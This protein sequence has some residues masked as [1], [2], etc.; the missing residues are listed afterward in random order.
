MGKIFDKGLSEDDQKEGLFKRLESIE[1]KNE[2]Q[3]QGIKDREEKKLREIKNINK[4]NTLKVIDEIRKKMMKQIRYYLKLRIKIQN[5]I[6]Q[7]LFEQKLMELN[8]TLI[9]CTPIKIC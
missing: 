6:L 3:L 1:S 8:T 7:N 9:L 5:L 2:V 4:N